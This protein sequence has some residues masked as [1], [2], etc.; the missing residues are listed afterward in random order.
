MGQ[1]KRKGTGPGPRPWAESDGRG[2]RAQGPGPR[3][4]GRTDA[5]RIAVR[6]APHGFDGVAYW[7]PHARSACQG[8]LSI[9]GGH[10]RTKI[11]PRYAC[12]MTPAASTTKCITPRAEHAA[13]S[14]HPWALGPM[15]WALSLGPSVLGPQSWAL[16]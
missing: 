13:L 7:L 4:Q 8:L 5:G 3:A 12:G 11:P 10:S 16:S 6:S 1:V 15:P 14:I 2:Q 9:T